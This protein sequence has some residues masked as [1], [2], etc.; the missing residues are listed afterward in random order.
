MSTPIVPFQDVISPGNGTTETNLG[1]A[2]PADTKWAGM[3]VRVVNRTEHS[4]YVQVL[5]NNGTED[6][7][8]WAPVMIEG[9]V[10]AH[11]SDPITMLTG[12]QAKLRVMNPDNLALELAVRFSGVEV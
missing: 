9:T 11:R 4:C 7:E 6:V 1:S 3:L 2:V 10:G 5:V 12:N 8:D